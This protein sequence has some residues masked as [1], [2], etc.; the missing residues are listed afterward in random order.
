MPAAT[1]F[2]ATVDPEIFYVPWSIF[3][4]VW[5]LGNAKESQPSATRT[6]NVAGSAAVFVIAAA[7]IAFS[8]ANACA[9]GPGHLCNDH[10]GSTT[11]I[12]SAEV[13]A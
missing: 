7:A 3:V 4:Y 10:S 5:W 6:Q 9:D 1:A 12:A 13:H 11:R 2:A 8:G